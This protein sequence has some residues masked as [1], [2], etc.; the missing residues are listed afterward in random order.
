MPN[1]TIPA[2]KHCILFLCLTAVL[3]AQGAPEVEITAEPHHHLVLENAFIRVFSLDVPPHTESLMH[4]HRHDYIYV[5]LGPTEVVN[6]VEGKDPVTV[7]LVEGETHFSP[8]PFAHIARNIS[9]QP[10]RNLTIEILDDAKL[11]QST[12]KWDE[13]RGLDILQGGT[14]QVLFVKDSIRVTEF[15]LLPGGVV[16]MHH[17][18]GPHLLVAV[19]D[20]D[21]QEHTRSDA[22]AQSKR[23]LR[24]EESGDCEWIPGGYS[25]SI[26]NVG[27]HPAKFVTLEFP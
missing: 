26:T 27:A 12:A 4:R 25:H 11:R 19:S 17:H 8:G 21:L 14:K 10:F 1:A 2:M 3:A 23:S 22:E 5:M 7:K 15:E 20:L 13:D 9:D 16:P 18:A 6:A 24:S